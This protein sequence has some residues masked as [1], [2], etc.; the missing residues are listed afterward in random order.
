MAEVHVLFEFLY[1]IFNVAK[2]D[3]TKMRMH[4]EELQKRIEKA[5]L[6]AGKESLCLTETVYSDESTQEEKPSRVRT[7][8]FVSKKKNKEGETFDFYFRLLF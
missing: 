7:I 2:R 4:M 5:E 6:A 8:K 1:S 3:L